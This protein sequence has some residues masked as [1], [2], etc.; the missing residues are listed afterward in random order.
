MEI[1]LDGGDLLAPRPSKVIAV[2]LNYASRAAQRGRVPEFPS[3]FLKPP[4][5]IAER[6][7]DVVRP[8][9]CELLAFEGEIALVIGEPARSVRPE[10]GFDH[11]AY[12]TAAN[13][14]GVY[15][16]R[17]ADKGSNLRS[18]GGDGFTPVGPRLL[19]AR[20]I[21]A[22]T[23]VVRTWLN[24]R[25]V[26]EAAAADE[27]LFP[28]GALVADLSRLMT[29]ERGDLVLTGTPT[30][31]TVAEPGD[32]VEVEVTAGLATTGRLTTRV[33]AAGAGSLP[34]IGAMPRRDEESR[35]AAY[36]AVPPVPAGPEAT[37]PEA[38]EEARPGEDE[39]ALV[40]V[41]RPLASATI[42][43]Q[44]R[45]HGLDG[46]VMV[47]LTALRGEEKMVGR[48]RTV[49]YLPSREDV[50]AAKGG[51][52]N[53]QKRAI[54]AIEP[55]EVLVIEARGERGAGTIGDI[56][57]LRARER[58]AVG[59]VTD[60]PIRDAAAIERLGLPVFHAGTNPAVLGR[61]HVPFETDV[62]VACAGVLVEPGDLLVGDADGVVVVPRHVAAQVAREAAEQE[63][64]ERFI[65]EQVARGASIEGLY[66]LGPSYE[67]AYRRW[68]DGGGADR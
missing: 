45:K 4:S 17:Y 24:G 40:E 47:G 30:G 3:Y 34:A 58:G 28:L 59:V 37:E 61:R 15:D 18:K 57:A 38:A 52:M 55:G 9:G 20:R 10:E 33:V 44:L 8:D 56:L 39:E 26:Q 68:C 48:A 31:S 62:A 12:V 54:E 36:G 53:A 22:S 13:D 21:D 51:G 50:F 67:D 46:V 41:L 43:Q 6:G 1:S 32:V 65:T 60:G 16:L 2:H 27:L 66:P 42:A 5:S 14:L 49:R 11:V 7:G 64:Q 63:R 23:L 19:D 25:L 29:L 35:A